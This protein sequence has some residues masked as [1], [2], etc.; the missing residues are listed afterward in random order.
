M[1]K[2]KFILL[3]AIAILFSACGG[4]SSS[5]PA[6]VVPVESTIEGTA[7]DELIVNGIIT[8]YKNPNSIKLGSIRTDENGSYEMTIRD[9][10]GV[11][12]VEVT[13]DKDSKLKR[14]D[15]TFIDC[16]LDTRLRTMSVTSGRATSLVAHISP[17]TEMAYQRAKVL[18]GGSSNIS[19]TAFEQAR[20]EIGETFGVDPVNDSPAEGIYDTIIDSIHNVAEDNNSSFQEVVDAFAEDSNDGS[21]G[22]FISQELANAISNN[23]VSNNLTEGNGEYLPSS[24]VNGNDNSS[25]S[26]NATTTNPQLS[27]MEAIAKAKD[28]FTNLRTKTLSIVDYESTNKDGTLDVELRGFSDALNKFTIYGETASVY[29]T[30]ILNVIFDAL[31][32][33]RNDMSDIIGDGA[34]FAI[35]V[36]KRS[37]TIWSY[38]FGQND[39]YSG[40]IT[41]P[42]DNPDVY[43][44]SN[45]YS[46]LNFEFDGTLPKYRVVHINNNDDISDSGVQRLV[47][48][49]VVD[50]LSDSEIRTTLTNGTLSSDNEEIKIPKMVDSSSTLSNGS[51]DKLEE[52]AFNGVVGD[53]NFDGRIDVST[54]MHN[55][56]VVENSGYLPKEIAYNGYIL[57]NLNGTQIDA[58]IIA[59]WKDLLLNDQATIDNHSYNPLLDVTI[60]GN[61]KVVNQP[62]ST[63]NASYENFSDEHRDIS[64]S[65]QNDDTIVN[66]SGSFTTPKGDNGTF[67][68]SNHI[69][70]YAQFILVD[71]RVVEGNIN[72]DGSV[73]KKDGD[74]IG[75]LEYRNDILVV[76]YTDGS[77]ESIF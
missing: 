27:N 45:N 32:L 71:N 1:I 18:S 61:I 50:K 47:G 73:V 23:N 5:S 8:A 53:Y 72:G 7:I 29:K 25:S 13:C 38:R 56:K 16:P 68:V 20:A 15:G 9:Y 74:I 34:G 46:Q 44:D 28:M 4:G 64:I 30:Y 39:I 69:G 42:T 52:I 66:S 37:A 22:S 43:M 54:Y 17:L 21:V 62:E 2:I 3:F 12:V 58:R 60:N 57:N 35:T 40:T 10:L 55:D 70:I 48:K 24:V 41:I 59:E 36:T 77:F 76:N 19:V 51:Y 26:S 11:V 65:F 14:D 63:I 6:V 67:R 33:G 31:K 75:M 49:I